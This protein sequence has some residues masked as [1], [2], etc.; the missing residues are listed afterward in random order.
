IAGG[1]GNYAVATAT[2]PVLCFSASTNV[3]LGTINFPSAKLVL[4]AD[5]TVLA[6]EGQFSASQF[7]SKQLN[8]YSLPS[9]QLITTFRFG[10]GSPPRLRDMS[11]SASGTVIGE[12]LYNNTLV[13]VPAAGGMPLWTAPGAGFPWQP[14]LS[15]DGTLAAI[16]GAPPGGG[17]PPPTT[18]IY[19]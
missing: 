15:P 16:S 11:L 8:V 3:L 13:A 9:V 17:Q 19:R 10:G 12:E 14:L 6:A 5:G 2:G 1:A 18:S 7:T 4:S